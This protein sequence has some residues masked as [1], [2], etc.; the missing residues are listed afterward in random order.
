MKISSNV[1]I[2]ELDYVFISCFFSFKIYI[3][4]YS[5]MIQLTLNTD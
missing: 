2:L 4:T 5:P 3:F 1:S